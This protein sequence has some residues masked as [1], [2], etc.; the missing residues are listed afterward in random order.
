[1]SVDMRHALRH[2]ECLANPSAM[3][4][5]RWEGASTITD[6]LELIAL[7][8]VVV[9]FAVSLGACADGPANSPSRRDVAGKYF[10]TT[11][12]KSFLLKKKGFQELPESQIHVA[13]NG[14]IEFLELPD[15]AENGFGDGNGK[16]LSGSG[17]WDLGN[18]DWGYGITATVERGGTLEHGVHHAS[19]MLLSGKGAPFKIRIRLGDPDQNEF[20]VYEKQI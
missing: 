14:V 3:Q 4:G 16:F 17:K 2:V 9:V 13:S 20:F 7:W 11:D 15:C 10:L 1:M 6:V 8:L 19:W 5:A 12:S 18:T